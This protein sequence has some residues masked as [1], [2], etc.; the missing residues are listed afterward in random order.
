MRTISDGLVVLFEGVDGVGKTTQLELAQ[1]E[2]FKQGWS[3]YT[4]RNLGGTPIGE[5]LRDALLDRMHRPPLTD[6]YVSVGIQAALLEAIESERE[7][8]SIVL[9]D[10]SPLSLAAYQIFGSGID[11]NTGWPYVDSGMAGLR[12]ELTLF[13]ETKNLE[14]AIQRA[15][16]SSA[17]ADYFES[18]PLSYF[19]RVSE[20]YKTAA[21]RHAVHRISADQS[22]QKV[23]EQTMKQIEAVML[24]K[25]ADRA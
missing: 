9:L 17:K 10:R 3:V 23:H 24:A 5:A 20:G 6:L 21:K 16:Q 22:I 1:K 25:Q 15:R 11:E 18:K 4:A 8:G 19:E 12:A 13:Y 14:T 2:L 7:A